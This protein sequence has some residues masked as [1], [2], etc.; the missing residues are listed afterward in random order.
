MASDKSFAHAALNLLVAVQKAKD[1]SGWDADWPADRMAEE[2]LEAA[3]EERE[4]ICIGRNVWGRGITQEDALN[5]MVR[6]G[7]KRSEYI[8]FSCPPGCSVSDFDGS[9]HYP[10]SAKLLGLDMV[11]E[12]ARKPKR[13]AAAR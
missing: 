13:R 5:A 6:A 10:N 3:R 7:G 4:F 12:V 1:A 9:I 11:K 2:L 8:M